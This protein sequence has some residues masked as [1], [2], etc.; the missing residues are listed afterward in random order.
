MAKTT[1]SSGDEINLIE[2]I[3]VFLTHKTK[4]ILLG[5]VGLLLGLGYSYQHEPRYETQFKLVVQHPAFTT[6]ELIN[7]TSIQE[8]I[9][10]SELNR[11]KL[12]NYSYNKRKKVFV[13]VTK[14]GEVQNMVTE[15][16]ENALKEQVVKIKQQAQ[17]F[18]GFENNQVIINHKTGLQF[19]NQD[20]AKLNSDQVMNSFNLSFGSP[21]A[22][23]PKPLKHGVI[24]IFVGLILAFLWMMA[25]ILMRQLKKK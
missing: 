8:L 23:Y 10:T 6:N 11:D 7:S 5:V 18:K 17:D 21:K 16:F 13:V 1:P 2:I 20:L 22:L 14:G 4:F 12:P 9:N 3:E 25:D 19:N 15:T 24:G